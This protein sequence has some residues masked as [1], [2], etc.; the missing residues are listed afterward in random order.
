MKLIQQ[1]DPPQATKGFFRVRRL[2]SERSERGSRFRFHKSMLQLAVKKL[3]PALSRER[4]PVVFQV[5]L[6]NPDR[7]RSSR[8]FFVELRDTTYLEIWQSW[9]IAK[10][11]K[12]FQ[13]FRGG[14]APSISVTECEQRAL[15]FLFG[16]EP[17]P[18]LADF[19]S[20]QSRVVPVLWV[21]KAMRQ[22]TAAIDAFPPVDIVGKRIPFVPG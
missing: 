18:R 8:N 1:E 21:G 3:D 10:P 5:F 15:L 12:T 20:R 9:K 16:S 19:G 14:T 7:Q 22:D 6:A 13:H 17:L 4:G 11:T 2:L